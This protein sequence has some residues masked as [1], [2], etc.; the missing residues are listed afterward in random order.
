MLFMYEFAVLPE[1][2]SL[3]RTSIFGKALVVAA[4]T[5]GPPGLLEVVR[6][7]KVLRLLVLEVQRIFPWLPSAVSRVVL[8]HFRWCRERRCTPAAIN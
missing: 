4:R 3:F 5:R 6:T 7:L 1:P 8:G 2:G